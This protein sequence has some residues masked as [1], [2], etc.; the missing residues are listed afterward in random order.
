MA[1]IKLVNVLFLVSCRA[2]ISELG[3][4]KA[5]RGHCFKTFKELASFHIL[6][7]RLHIPQNLIFTFVELEFYL[8]D[9][10]IKVGY[11]SG[12]G[13]GVDIIYRSRGAI[14]TYTK[15][16]K[17]LASF[18]ILNTRLH[19][20][21]NLIFT[22]VELEFYLKD[23]RIKISRRDKNIYG[24]ILVRSI[25][26]YWSNQIVKGSCLIVEIILNS[27]GYKEK[28]NDLFLTTDDESAKIKPPKP[29]NTGRWY[30]KEEKTVRKELTWN[31]SSFN[32]KCESPRIGKGK[33]QAISDFNDI[34]KVAEILKVNQQAIINHIQ[35]LGYGL[36]F[37]GDIKTFFL[38]IPKWVGILSNGWG[39]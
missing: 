4:L 23:E 10:R 5:H 2:L 37:S 27:C 17:E 25:K 29:A 22:F 3:E 18:H 15:T 19:I 32:S 36:N 21:Q 24:D 34:G 12:S 7:T 30:K 16:F 39:D 6:N 11:R 28:R 9:E 8:K 13:K 33:A 14:K 26:D 20:P 1:T 31:R 35:E 38:E